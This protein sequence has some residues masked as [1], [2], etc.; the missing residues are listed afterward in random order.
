MSMIGNFVAIRPAA[1]EAFIAEPETLENFLYPDDGSEPANCL[2][3]DKAWHAIHFILN[4]K[5]WG[6]EGA[7]ALAVLGG[8][9]IGEDVGYGPARYLTAEGVRTV[10]E[11]LAQVTAEEFSRRYDPKAMDAAEIYPQIW[12]QEGREALEYVLE[13]Y[14]QLVRFYEAAAKRGDGALLYLN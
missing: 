14:R 2:S 5:P 3:V 9:E 7:C 10:A 8:T 4:G 12:I 13:Y 1:L 6:G 11:A